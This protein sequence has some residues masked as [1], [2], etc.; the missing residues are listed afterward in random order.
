MLSIFYLYSSSCVWKSNK[1]TLEC[2][3]CHLLF[4]YTEALEFFM[5]LFLG[6]FF[7]TFL[8]SFLLFLGVNW[9][10]MN[11][12]AVMMTGCSRQRNDQKSQPV[13]EEKNNNTSTLLWQ[14]LSFCSFLYFWSDFRQSVRLSCLSF[15]PCYF[16]LK[17]LAQSFLNT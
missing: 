3:Q 2:M 14:K 13:Q 15:L 8:S 12:V 7:Q 5:N 11:Q 6:Q 10:L 9:G 16:C 17:I 4:Y 1:Y